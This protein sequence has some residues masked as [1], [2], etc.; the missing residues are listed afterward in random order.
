MVSEG[1]AKRII[2]S[3]IGSNPIAGKLMTEGKL[4]S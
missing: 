2:A 1:R 4:G 3:H